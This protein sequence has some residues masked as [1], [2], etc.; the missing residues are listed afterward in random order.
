MLRSKDRFRILDFDIENRPG[1]Y[2][3]DGN[4][5]SDVTA[6]AA[7]FVGSDRVW[8]FAMGG[9]RTDAEWEEQRREMLFRFRELYDRADVVAGHYITRHDLPI[10]DGAFLRLGEDPLSAKFVLDTKT[11]FR[12]T[13]G[14][15]LSQENLAAMLELEEQ[16]HHMNMTAWELANRGTVEGAKRAN[17]R[18]RSDVKS[19]KE[20][21]R[22]IPPAWLRPLRVWR[23]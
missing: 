4:C 11:G 14:V 15:S 16:K 10:L 13:G 23:P 12:R 20:L 5:S 21:L 3:Y 18:V 8:S 1:A 9:Y 7:S 22:A 6:I 17:A 19:H 2:W